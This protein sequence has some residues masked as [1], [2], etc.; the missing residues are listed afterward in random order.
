MLAA[1][2][3]TWQQWEAG[4]RSMPLSAIELWCITVIA[5]GQ[6]PADDPF[7]SQWV[8]QSVLAALARA[9]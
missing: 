4:D 2:L 1:G 3:R 6:L 8:R 7:A 5:E 9:A